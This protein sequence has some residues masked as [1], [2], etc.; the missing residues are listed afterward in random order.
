MLG[1]EALTRPDPESGLTGP[2]EAFDVAEQI[3]CVRAL[4]MLCVGHARQITPELP[5]G[6]LL[7]VNLS[8]QTLDLDSDGNDWFCDAVKRAGLAPDRVV[9]EVT[10]RFGGRSAAILATVRRLRAHGFKIAID[11][12]GTGNSGLEMLRTIQAEYVKIDRSIVVAAAGDP[13]ARAVLM[14]MATYA[15]MTGSFVIAEGIEELDTLDFLRAVE[16]SDTLHEHVIQGG[17]GYGLGR[18][19]PHVPQQLPTLLRD[20]ITWH[21]ILGVKS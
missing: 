15:R 20:A 16:D 21:P 6:A 2:A 1:V 13:S 19:H 5:D 14:A 9:V 10:E 7:F 12:V 3:G 17:Q 18:P 4:D 8:P 11:D